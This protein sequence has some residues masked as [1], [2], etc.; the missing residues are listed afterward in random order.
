VPEGEAPAE[1]TLER[2]AAMLARWRDPGGTV[3]VVAIDGH[4]AS[5]KSTI[6]GRLSALTGAALVHTD[7][8]FS[9]APAL[10]PGGGGRDLGSYYDVPRLRWEALEPLRA[11][12]E[13]SYRPY[14]WDAGTLAEEC[15]HVAPAAL[16]ILEGVYSAS[17]ALSDLV[18]KAV[19]VRTP[20]PERLR[21]LRRNGRRRA[22]TAAGRPAPAR[23]DRLPMRV[24]ASGARPHAGNRPSVW[25]RRFPRG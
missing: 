23:V 9:P 15:T 8:F 12:R 5:G 2:A 1:G 10:P 17:P 20:E 21:R 3:R 16:V 18:D 11:G 24:P 6:A 4:G 25:S 19:Y 22:G 13:A 7:D 14:D